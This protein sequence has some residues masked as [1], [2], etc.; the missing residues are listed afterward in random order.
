MFA[1]RER[2]YKMYVHIYIHIETTLPLYIYIYLYI[3]IHTHRYMYIDVHR[4]PSLHAQGARCQDKKGLAQVR[5]LLNAWNLRI[6]AFQC[7]SVSTI[8]LPGG[9]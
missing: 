6:C 2:W 1:A 8:L 3:Y 4:P 5:P 7:R 9:V